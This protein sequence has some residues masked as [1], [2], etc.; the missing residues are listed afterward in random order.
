MKTEHTENYVGQTEDSFGEGLEDLHE[1][2]ANFFA[3]ICRI[4]CLLLGVIQTFIS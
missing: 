1:F 2:F 4:T 3:H